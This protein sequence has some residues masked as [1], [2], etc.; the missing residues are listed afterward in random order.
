M[1]FHGSYA[2]EDVTFLLKPLDYVDNLPP[3]AKE[4]AMQ[5]G[6]RH[7][8]E[9][10]TPETLPSAR[11]LALF[12]AALQENGMQMAHDCNVLATH[13]AETIPNPVLVSLARAGTPVGVVLKHLLSRRLAS[14]IAHYS[15]SIIRDRGIDTNALNYILKQHDHSGQNLVFID[16]W[17]GKGVI[18]RELEKAIRDYNFSHKTQI[19]ARLYVLSDLAGVAWQS[20]SYSDYLIPSAILNATVSGLVSRSVLNQQIGENDF[21]GCL[22]YRDFAGEDRSRYFVRTLLRYAESLPTETFSV[23]DNRCKQQQKTK[24][25]QFIAAQ[26]RQYGIQDINLIKPGIGEATRVLLRRLPEKIIVQNLNDRAVAHLI[27]LAEE[28][29]VPVA[30]HPDLPFLATAIIRSMQ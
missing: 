23:P 20:A 15:I 13:I 28:K 11:Y 2:P 29:N 19:P 21:H 6:I 24:M 8:S 26:C 17:T 22:Y 27:A 14:E 3:E 30:I 16:G 12:D 4:R 1:T 9:M 18:N 5:Q 7:Y 10:L 25:Q